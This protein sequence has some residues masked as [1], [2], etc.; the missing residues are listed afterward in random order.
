MNNNKQRS[1]GGFLGRVVIWGGLGYVAG[2]RGSSL[3][4]WTFWGPVSEQILGYSLED[5]VAVMERE[6][7]KK[8]YEAAL[9]N[10]TKRL[11]EIDLSLPKI[12]KIESLNSN[13]AIP[14]K[15]ILAYSKWRE[16]IKHPAIVLVLGGRGSGKSAV[17]YRVVEDF[18]YSLSPYVVGFP[19][20]SK[21]LLPE[22]IGIEERLE[23]VPPKS[24]IIIDE[25]YL[26]HHAR[27]W[28]KTG[29]RDIS[30]LLN[31]SR[32]QDKTIVFIAQIGRQLDIDIVSSADVLILKNPGML[33]PKFDRPEFRDLL[34]EAKQA[35]QSVKSNIKRWSYVYSQNTNFTGL[36][37]NDLPSFW[38]PRLSNAYAN[39]GDMA[40]Q[41]LPKKMT[42]E[43]KIQKAKEL[44]AKGW[45]QSKIAEYLGVDSKGTIFNWIHDYPYRQRLQEKG[46]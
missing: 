12:N 8:E 17:S 45:S 41:K 2:L 19:E 33:Q 43:E 30:R 39:L 10:L 36:I 35:F 23:D 25:V 46:Q 13:L 4:N 37:E 28:Q 29:N 15:Q 21:S 26:S 38:S 14:S 42:R 20:K 34:L 7:Q 9:A 44:N 31:L 22:W 1:F 11:S 6:R 40:S 5:I 32:Q 27:E 18:R 16:V 24:I 3:K